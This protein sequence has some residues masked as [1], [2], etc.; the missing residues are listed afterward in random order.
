M[1]DNANHVDAAHGIADFYLP[2]LPPTLGYPSLPAYE[3]L[4]KKQLARA[5]GNSDHYKKQGRVKQNTAIDRI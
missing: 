1:W 4:C 2:H 3:L 5:F